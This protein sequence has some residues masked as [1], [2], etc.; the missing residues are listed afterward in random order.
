MPGVFPH[1]TFKDKPQDSDS[2]C[3]STT[4]KNKDDYLGSYF[5]DTNDQPLCANSNPVDGEVGLS[6]DMYKWEQNT[7]FSCR[8]L[9]TSCEVNCGLI[10]GFFNSDE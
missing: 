7:E 8:I 6:F 1:V 3:I 2:Y 10:G 5:M 9:G 4:W